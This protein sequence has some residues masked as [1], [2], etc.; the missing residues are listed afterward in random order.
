MPVV[1]ANQSLV[2]SASADSTI[3]IWDANSW[4]YLGKYTGHTQAV[5]SLEYLDLDSYSL[6]VSGSL[7]NTIQLWNITTKLSSFQWNVSEHGAA[8]S[9]KAIPNSAQVAS[10]H[11]DGKILIWPVSEG[12][13]PLQVLSGHSDVVFDLKII[14]NNRLASASWDSTII[15]WNLNDYSPIKTLEGHNNKVFTLLPLI[16]DPYSILLSASA[17]DTV[18]MW[19]LK[20]LTKLFQYTSNTAGI[21]RA[22]ELYNSTIFLSGSKMDDTL[23]AWSIS[24]RE[25]IFSQN[26]GLNITTVAVANRE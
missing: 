24:G 9:L 23:R 3:I 4:Q 11:N 7:D 22:L 5:E 6:M 2:V 10:G 17:D 25:V 8:W 26:I 13:N 21:Y 19:N 20:N 16:Y 1:L 18:I 12:I 14:E 15:I